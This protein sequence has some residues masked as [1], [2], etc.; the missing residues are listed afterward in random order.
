MA[1]GAS[2]DYVM[3]VSIRITKTCVHLLYIK[4]KQ[5][6]WNSTSI[7]SHF[8]EALYKQLVTSIP[9]DNNRI[10]YCL[11]SNKASTNRVHVIALLGNFEFESVFLFA[12]PSYCNCHATCNKHYT[13]NVLNTK[14]QQKEGPT[15]ACPCLNLQLIPFSPTFF[16]PIGHP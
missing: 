12:H 7:T 5:F 3:L 16:W 9:N 2:C 8:A 14:W 6:L 11:K 4:T 13:H 15:L 10:A 1:S